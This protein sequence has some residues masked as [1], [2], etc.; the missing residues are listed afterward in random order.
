MPAN[1]CLWRTG[2]S[3]S[4]QRLNLMTCAINATS[5]EAEETAHI[6]SEMADRSAGSTGGLDV[7]GRYISV[8]KPMF[9]K[10]NRGIILDEW[11][12]DAG[13]GEGSPTGVYL[14]KSGWEGALSSEYPA[15]LGLEK[16]EEGSYG[17]HGK[18]I[19]QKIKTD[20]YGKVKEVCYLVTLTKPSDPYVLWRGARSPKESEASEEYQFMRR[21]GRIMDSCVEMSHGSTPINVVVETNDLVMPILPARAE[22]ECKTCIKDSVSLIDDFKDNSIL[23]KNI[24]SEGGMKITNTKTAIKVLNGI[25]FYAAEVPEGEEGEEEAE[26]EFPDVLPHTE[27]QGF[28]VTVACIPIKEQH[29]KWCESNSTWK[30]VSSGE[31]TCQTPKP[32]CKGTIKIQAS[33]FNGNNWQIGWKSS[34][35]IEIP[36]YDFSPATVKNY[37]AGRGINICCKTVDQGED[38]PSITEYII[39]NTM[40]IEA[41]C[42]INVCEVDCGGGEDAPASAVYKISAAIAKVE[43]GEG[44]CIEQITDGVRVGSTGIVITA[45]KGISVAGDKLCWEITNTVP[46]TQVT[47]GCGISVCKTGNVYKVSIKQSC[48][49]SCQ[50]CSTTY[51][52]DANWFTVTNNHVTLKQTKIDKVAEQL[53]PTAVGNITTTKTTAIIDNIDGNNPLGG[54]NADVIATIINSSICAACAAISIVKT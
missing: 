18:D 54:A 43:A 42:G 8:I 3:L 20:E 13:E 15:S 46:E 16:I 12:V 6:V 14:R 53:A 5:E 41:G 2:D 32:E 9:D 24:A 26:P 11:T 33:T 48:G 51:T 30:P 49:S 17:H 40:K 38:N 27:P 37:Q 34:G 25:E 21:V 45:G 52:F 7:N 44:I 35:D 29:Y 23:F 1:L 4:A 50:P 47:G 36:V 39:C 19:Y 31:S 10:A 22:A 28:N